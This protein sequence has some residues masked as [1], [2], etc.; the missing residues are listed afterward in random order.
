L[1]V[2]VLEQDNF[3]DVNFMVNYI[4]YILLCN[5]KKS[6]ALSELFIDL[7]V[8][9]VDADVNNVTNA[10]SESTISSESVNLLKD[11]AR[12]V[13][14]EADNE[15]CGLKGCKIS[16]YIDLN[17]SDKSSNNNNNNTSMLEQNYSNS[18]G[19]HLV[20]QFS[21]DSS[22]PMTTFELNI[23]LKQKKDAKIL[24]KTSE[25]SLENSSFTNTL[26]RHLMPQRL[27]ER[28]RNSPAS[29]NTDEAILNSIYNNNNNNCN[30]KPNHVRSNSNSTI[31]KTV[32]LDSVDCE[33]LKRKLY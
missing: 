3:F 4:A 5:I 21:F 7:K 16:I 20:N 12:R 25:Q 6:S 29:E 33:L 9:D 19:V 1:F 2:F 10:N 18:V 17:D 13:Y 26:T 8:D 11:L 31:K 23:L 28:F 24:N 30:N 22:S 27:F 14:T 15:P 32:L